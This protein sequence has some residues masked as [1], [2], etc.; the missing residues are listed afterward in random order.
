MIRFLLFVMLPFTLFSQSLPITLEIAKTESERI[1]GLMQRDSLPKD[2][3]MLFVYEKPKYLSVWMFNCFINL[4]AAF[5]DSKG[6]IVEI[7]ELTA[8]PRMMDP[9]RPIETIDDLKLYSPYD[10][11][12]LFFRKKSVASSYKVRY[13]L[14]MEEGWFAKHGVVPG[15][16]L[17]WKPGKKKAVIHTNSH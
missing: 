7:R 2:H 9:K 16:R 8:Y 13:V 6:Y 15:D 10:P 17:V 1:W 14:E 11:I 4:S 12:V 3:G 5:I